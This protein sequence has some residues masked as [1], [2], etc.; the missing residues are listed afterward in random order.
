MYPS[1]TAFNK[2]VQSL[3]ERDIR[4]KC[5]F[6][7]TTELDGNYLISYTFDDSINSSNGISIGECC[8]KQIK[9]SLKMP[10]TPIP[11]TNGTISPF[12]GVDT[13][14]GYD[15]DTDGIVVDISSGNLL[16]TIGDDCPFEFSVVDG[17]LIIESQIEADIEIDSDP[18]MYIDGNN[19]MRDY[20]VEYIPLGYFYTSA[21][22]TTNNYKT[23]EVTGYDS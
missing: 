10:E 21:P 12:V 15:E 1:S 6:N 22:S 11:L 17:N 4:L 16:L 19:L 7:D 13:Y 3:A 23:V 9:V 14:G 5:T 8:S 20:I 2:T 18:L